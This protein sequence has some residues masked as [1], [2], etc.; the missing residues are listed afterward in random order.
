MVHMIFRSHRGGVFYTPENTMP[1]F[2]DA[3]KKGF[4]YIETD[5]HYTKDGKLI[6]MHD[7]YINRT[8]RN[9]DGSEIKERL[10]IADLT[11]DE[12]M[13][14]DAGIY[15]G[16]A[17]RGTKVPLLEELFQAAENTDSI[18]SLDKKIPDDRQDAIF[19]LVEKYNVKVSFSVQD[20]AR[21]K[22]I[23]ARFPDAMIDYDGNTTEEDL[24]IITSMVKPENL[25]V[26]MY[27]DNP[28]FAWLTD[29]MKASPENC[30][31][32]KKYA[33][34]GLG[35]VNNTYDMAEALSYDPYVIEV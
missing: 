14:Y 20:V 25:V 3:L 4:A 32:V 1:A 23:Q 8:C 17:F 2:H 11:Y 12:L 16:E 30:A 24:K 27:I 33:R 19:D 29:R 6:L 21:T 13:Q 15:M 26:W 28:A 9:K 22:I 35:N 7:F 31:R 10:K 18:I 34:L 5:P